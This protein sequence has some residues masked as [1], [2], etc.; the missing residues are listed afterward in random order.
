MRQACEYGINVELL[1]SQSFKSAKFKQIKNYFEFFLCVAVIEDYR[2]VL[3]IQNS[4]NTTKFI[5]QI[6]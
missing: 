5:P 4:K 6:N 2:A 1:K 3:M